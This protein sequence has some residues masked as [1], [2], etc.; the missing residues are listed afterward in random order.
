MELIDNNAVLAVEIEDMEAASR[1]AQSFRLKEIVLVDAKVSR[2]PEDA[3]QD[4]LSLEHKC[5]T[6]VLSWGGGEGED[7]DH[8]PTAIKEL[9]DG[10]VKELAIVGSWRTF[11]F[12][13]LCNFRVAA[14]SDEMPDKLI[15]EIE[16]SFCTTFDT[17]PGFE[18]YEDLG[19][20][21]IA[22]PKDLEYAINV[23]PISHAWP[24]WREFVQSMSARM[25][26]PA[27]TVPLLEIVPKKPAAKKA[28]SQTVKKESPRRKKLR[29]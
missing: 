21:A 1:A 2:D 25:G 26:F 14:F 13:F 19:D 28:K 18:L 5:S 29:A 12:S 24:Y 16:A 23:I 27:L 20:N 15:M 3:Y 10:L 22:V 4:V 17:I 9:P 6:E 11:R 7:E 8:L